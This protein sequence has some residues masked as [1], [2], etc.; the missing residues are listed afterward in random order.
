VRHPGR[1]LPPY[2]GSPGGGAT[3]SNGVKRVRSSSGRRILPPQSDGP[4]RIARVRPNAAQACPGT[5]SNQRRR[6]RSSR[7]PRKTR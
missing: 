6:A 2:P 5:G 7:K 3:D 1:R 4:R